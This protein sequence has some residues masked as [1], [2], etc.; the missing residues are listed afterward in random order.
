MP[1]PILTLNSSIY[2]TGAGKHFKTK[3]YTIPPTAGARFITEDEGNS[4]PKLLRSTMIYAP[5]EGSLVSQLGA[6]MGLVAQPMADL[7]EQ[8]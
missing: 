4:G 7:D 1:R 2:R 8:D 3:S 5:T 6:P